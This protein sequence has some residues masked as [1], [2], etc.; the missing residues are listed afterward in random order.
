M[1]F[2]LKYA[3]LGVVIVV[4]VASLL[5][6]QQQKIPLVLP[7][8]EEEVPI[9]GEEVAPGVVKCPEDYCLPPVRGAGFCPEWTGKA[10]ETYY[11]EECYDY[12]ETAASLAE[13]ET[14]KIV[15]YKICGV[16]P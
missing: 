12:P 8:I 2:Q 9:A 13:C 11:E 4:A 7:E 16:A 14:Q 15:Y 3:L 5:L 6:L 1:E 10:E